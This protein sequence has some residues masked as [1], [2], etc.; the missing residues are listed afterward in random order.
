[1]LEIDLH[2][3]Y[4]LCYVNETNTGLFNRSSKR[5]ELLAKGENKRE[6][7]VIRDLLN[8]G[9]GVYKK[10]R[11][12]STGDALR[13]LVKL[14]KRLHVKASDDLSARIDEYLYETP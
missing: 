8:K 6:P 2:T 5:I 14:G 11:K 10:T 12:V 4:M 1:M 3:T 9:L 7:E 13:R